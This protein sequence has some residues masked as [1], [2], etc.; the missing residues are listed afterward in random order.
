MN[1]IMIKTVIKNKVNK[2]GFKPTDYTKLKKFW[3]ICDIKV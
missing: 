3:K 2:Y 1:Q